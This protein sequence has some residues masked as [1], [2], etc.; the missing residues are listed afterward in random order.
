MGKVKDLSG[1]KFGRLTAIAMSHIDDG[2]R[3]LCQCEC[4]KQCVIRGYALT[5]GVTNS[6]GCLRLERS[7]LA[8]KTH[9]DASHKNRAPEYKIWAGMLARC[10]NPNHISFKRYGERGITVCEEWTSYENFIRDMGHRPSQGHSLERRDNYLGYSKGNCFWATASEQARNR[11][12]NKV[13]DT[14]L[15]PMLLCE[16]AEISGI[17]VQCIKHRIKRGWKASD[18]F[19][20]PRVTNKRQR[21][22]END[23]SIA[24]AHSYS[25]AR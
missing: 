10:T 8:L 23:G 2:A 22:T 16:A 25:Y 1:R 19:N 24:S 21:E 11:R 5:G 12:G 17:A 7:N 6:C 18:L 15:G 4:G 20:K 3:W 13:I 14:P 9:G